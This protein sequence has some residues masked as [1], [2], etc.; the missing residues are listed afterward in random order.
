M[1]LYLKYRPKS[2]EDVVGN[3]IVRDALEKGLRTENVHHALLFYGESGTGKTTLARILA[4]GLNCEISSLKPCLECT[5][6][7]SIL[8][9][10]CP[11]YIEVNAANMRGIDD[12]RAIVRNMDFANTYLK[13]RVFVFDECH[14]WT[15]EAQNCILKALE[16]PEPNTYIIL[17]TTDPSKL[18][19]TVRSRCEEYELRPLSGLDI[20]TL[21]E[22]VCDNENVKLSPEIFGGFCLRCSSNPRKLLTE[23]SKLLAQ[24]TIN[25]ET[26]L[27]VLELPTE[28]DDA[29]GF[30]IAKLLM[31]RDYANVVKITKLLDKTTNC[32]GMRRVILSYAKSCLLGKYP[33]QDL[34][35]HILNA[36]V[37][38]LEETVPF[39]DFVYRLYGLIYK[40]QA[41]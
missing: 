1:S 13:N 30:E 5:S 9:N 18:L 25:L 41:K 14:Q 19:K 10:R 38:P 12:V 32:E 6:C 7:K 16:E 23:L 17:C 37:K 11:D 15:N 29:N 4:L 31:K 28:E 40:L 35:L 20:G 27:S 3:T 24:P 21:V 26:M 2:L 33:V 39:E 22:R 34:P 36:F 8:E